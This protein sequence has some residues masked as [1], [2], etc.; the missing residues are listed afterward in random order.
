VHWHRQSAALWYSTDDDGFLQLVMTL[1]QDG[2][3]DNSGILSLPSLLFHV[4]SYLLGPPEF[5]SSVCTISNKHA[6]TRPD[7]PPDPASWPQSTQPHSLQSAYS[8]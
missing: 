7:S 5:H 8:L 6:S 2:G 3:I 1:V 4:H